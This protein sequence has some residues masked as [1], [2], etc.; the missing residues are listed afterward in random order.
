MSGRQE[1][2]SVGRTLRRAWKGRAWAGAGAFL[3]LVVVAATA[4]AR[5]VAEL[6]RVFHVG[7]GFG[8]I[9]MRG[10]FK[11]DLTVGFYLNEYVYLG[12]IVQAPDGIR[13]DG[14]S[15]NARAAGLDGLTSS[16]ETVSPRFLLHARVRPHRLAPFLSL[17]AV[18]NGRDTEV[19]RFDA[20]ERTIGDG[21]YDG[22]L[23]IRQSRPPGLRPA[24]GVGWEYVHRSGFS[25]AT[26]WAG[27]V[28]GRAPTPEIRISSDAPLADADR[29]ALERR[30]TDGFRRSI[31][32]RY[33]VF[34]IGAGYTF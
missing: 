19:M 25:L 10:S 2:W 29:A 8:E 28:I 12:A 18:Y 27:D 23:T 33:H 34:H 13:R 31:T 7:L 9:P 6:R 14:S 15:I 21:T 4:E 24:I 16:R 20:R 3:A 32:N 26:E 22:A 11:P 30:L 1:G 5:D 17:G